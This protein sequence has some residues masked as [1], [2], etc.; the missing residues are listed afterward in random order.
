MGTAEIANARPDGY[1]IGTP[2]DSILTLQPRLNPDVKF[3]LDSF[4][5]IKTGD[6][7]QL[8]VAKADAPYDDLVGFIQAAKAKPG[9]LRYGNPGTAT[10]NDLN[11]RALQLAAGI[12]L[13]SIPFA[14]GGADS[15]Q[16]LLRGDVEASIIVY[17]T[18]KGLVDSGDLKILGVLQ[19]E[20][21]GALP[22]VKSLKDFDLSSPYFHQTSLFLVVPSAT[23]AEVVDV[24]ADA[25]KETVGDPELVKTLAA[26]GTNSVYLGPEDAKKYLSELDTS[27]A[28]L[29]TKFPDLKP[30][31]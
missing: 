30:G 23:P 3:T 25:A 27:L 10:S 7:P 2:I 31:K 15:L 14:G 22:D 24:I 11:G 12:Q 13:R 18:V 4:T 1:E 21:M 26:Q 29:L 28:E 17:S 9:E 16:A 6:V 19:Q 8:V 20:R 5:S